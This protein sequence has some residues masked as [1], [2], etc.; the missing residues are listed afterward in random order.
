M[1]T[2]KRICKCHFLESAITSDTNE[3]FKKKFF[4]EI[5]TGE[6]YLFLRDA[7]RS[8]AKEGNDLRSTLGTI[9]STYI[10]V[11]SPFEINITASE[12][13][14][15][16]ESY[17]SFCEGEYT[18]VQ[19]KASVRSLCTSIERFCYE[20]LAHIDGFDTYLES[21]NKETISQEYRPEKA[22]EQEDLP[23]NAPENQVDKQV[24]YKGV[25]CT[26]F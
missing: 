23:A 20:N 17:D 26:L 14:S 25:C 24:C 11:D 5:Q 16:K 2:H 15:F 22:A 21:F 10:N 13:S 8:I 19:I 4:D 12:R 1:C 7:Y 3:G 18:E 9:A 6:H